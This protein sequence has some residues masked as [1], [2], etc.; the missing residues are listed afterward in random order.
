MANRKRETEAERAQRDREERI[1]LLKMKQ[2][3]IEE[4]ELIP[5]N[6]HV[7]M[8][9]LHGWAKISDFFYRNKAFVL[10]GTVFVVIITILVVQLVTRER[11]DLYIL[12]ISFDPDSEIGW[13]IDDLETTIEQYCP[14]YDG[15]GKVHVT[16]NYIDRTSDNFASQYYEAQAQKLS[17]EFMTANAQLFITDE[18]ILDWLDG[19]E[20]DPSPWDYK[21]VFLDQTELC[22]EDM[23]FNG[24]GVRV[25]KTAFAEKARWENCP[26]NVIILVRDELNNGR[27]SV[28][29][30]AKNR[31][32]AMTVLRNIVENN[33]VSPAADQ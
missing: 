4:S 33:V 28:K 20:D 13:R 2:G 25:S 15:N 31:E 3:I 8:P 23:L 24:V 9:K 5:E 19:D 22:S 16:I 10:I 30:N 26:D 32:R 6:E 11:E 27:S 1:A 17:L 12:A 29:T 18:K 14:D 21:K 7:E